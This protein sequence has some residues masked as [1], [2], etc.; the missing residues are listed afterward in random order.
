ML[1]ENTFPTSQY[2]LIQ[3]FQTKSEKQ[4]RI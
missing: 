3:T 2:E 1:R 4:P